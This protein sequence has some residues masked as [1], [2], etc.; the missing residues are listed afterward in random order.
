MKLL[1]QWSEQK[2]VVL[3]EP[4]SC[5]AMEE[6]SRQAPIDK[7]DTLLIQCT[8]MATTKKRVNISLAPDVEK[9]LTK[10]AHRDQVPQA[11][12]AGELLRR[13]IETEEDEVFDAIASTR[14]EKRV[15]YID[16]DKAWA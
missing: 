10:L 6:K 1:R 2:S 5:R 4:S 16:H 12:K 9:M 3:G 8:H 14:D 15:K 11:T 13:A 7:S